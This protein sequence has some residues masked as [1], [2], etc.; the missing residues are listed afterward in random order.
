METQIQD[1]VQTA[2]AL[3]EEIIILTVPPAVLRAVLLIRLHPQIRE[4]LQAARVVQAVRAA[5]VQA[6][7]QE[8]MTAEEAEAGNG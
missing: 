4:G 1:R 8:V 3:E 7:A 5:A 6:A 2:D